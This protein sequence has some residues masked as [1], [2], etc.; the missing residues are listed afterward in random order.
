[1]IHQVKSWL[2]T[3]PTHVSREHI[4]KYFDEFCFRINRSQSKQT[5]WHNAIMRMINN[6][7]L[8]W[9]QTERNL[10]SQLIKIGLK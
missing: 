6:K 5:T 1:M 8:N 7:P 10:I 4:Q 2:R 9:Y 3:T